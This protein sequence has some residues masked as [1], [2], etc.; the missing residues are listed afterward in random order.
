M[1]KYLLLPEK[2]LYFSVT[3]SVGDPWCLNHFTVVNPYLLVL[4]LKL[5]PLILAAVLATLKYHSIISLLDNFCYFPAIF[6]AQI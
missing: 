4:P 6:K 1:F 5:A 3:A 2:N